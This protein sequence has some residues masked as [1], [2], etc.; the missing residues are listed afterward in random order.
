MPHQTF[1]CQHDMDLD[2][3]SKTFKESAIFDPDKAWEDEKCGRQPM[4]QPPHARCRNGW[5]KVIARDR[6]ARKKLAVKLA[7]HSGNTSKVCYKFLQA[8]PRAVATVR[9]DSPHA[10]VSMVKCEPSRARGR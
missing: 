9:C 10:G 3:I 6:T 7:R 8:L 4:L 5:L 2:V 1:S